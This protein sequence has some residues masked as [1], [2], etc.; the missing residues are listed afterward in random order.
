MRLMVMFDMPT[1]TPAERKEYRQFRKFLLGE[2]F[3]MHQFSI[4]TKLVLND[5][6]TQA[7]LGRIDKNKPT[8]GIVTALKVTEK[9]YARMV[10]LIGSKDKSSGN[11]DARIVF[12]GGD[13]YAEPED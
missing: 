8:G 7:L 13:K 12:L 1:T 5:T 6:A 3:L 4:Y 11:T 9:Q 10:Y 2:G